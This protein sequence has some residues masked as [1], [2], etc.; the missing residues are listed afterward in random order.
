MTYGLCNRVIPMVSKDADLD[1]EY[2]RLTDKANVVGI[3]ASDYDERR[4]TEVTSL[5]VS[6][7]KKALDI[8]QTLGWSDV[9]VFAVEAFDGQE[10][11]NA[12]LIMKPADSE[13][14]SDRQAG[15]GIAPKRGR[16]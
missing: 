6:L 5:S 8:M 2:T 13:W 12:L 1:E 10:D 9:D 4:V 16:Q 14:G 7:M 11:D 3:D 15:I